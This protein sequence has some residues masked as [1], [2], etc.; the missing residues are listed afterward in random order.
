M[1]N[2]DRAI[3]S[4]LHDA[5]ETTSPRPGIDLAA[6][7]G[8]FIHRRALLLL[9][10]VFGLALGLAWAMLGSKTYEVRVVA[11][12]VDAESTFAS[13]EQA[14]RLASL[15]GLAAPE[16]VSRKDETIATL[17]SRAFLYSFIREQNLMPILFGPTTESS[18]K[19]A[20]GLERAPTLNEAYE[21]LLNDVI[22]VNEQRSTGLLEI[23]VRW[24][25]PDVAAAWAEQ[26]ISRL[27]RE[28]QQKARQR[29]EEEIAFLKAELAQTDVGEIRQ[30]IFNLIEAR[31]QAVMVA[32]VAEDY[33]LR[34]IDPPIAPDIHDSVSLSSSARIVLGIF[35]GLMGAVAIALLLDIKR[36]LRPPLD[37]A[38]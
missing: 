16:S 30:A 9:G 26:L 34:I 33:A 25:D 6:F 31:L 18:W 7:A 37:R 24:T 1:S 4:S 17:T 11:S 13:L 19:A 12:A 23:T 8:S 10:V 5:S 28:M 36:I 3:E 22:N 2:T 32:D 38:V 35:F 21:V 29:A 20:L 14:S 15:F 27:N